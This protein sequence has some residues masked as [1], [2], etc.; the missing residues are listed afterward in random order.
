MKKSILASAILTALAATA[1]AEQTPDAEVYVGAS[2]IIWDDDR[3]LDDASA[4]ELGLEVPVSEAL[5]V[6]LWGNDYGTDNKQSEDLD[7]NRYSLGGLYHFNN[8]TFRPFVTLGGS[9][10]EMDY[11]KGT[12]DTDSLIYAGVGAKNYFENNIVV[13]GDLIAM[14]SLDHEVTD[15]AARIALGYAF[16]DT[17]ASAKANAKADAAAKQ[18]QMEADKARAAAAKA[19]AKAEAQ[20]AAEKAKAEAAKKATMDEKARAAAA[21]AASAAN[22]DADKDGVANSLDKC[23]ETN[24]AY[25][26]DA[27]GCPVKLN[28]TVSIKMNVQF[29]TNSTQV[30]P[31]SEAEIAAL[32]KFLKQFE[33]TNVTV[34]GHTDD[35]GRAA[36]NKSLSQKR[37]DAVKAKL[38]KEHGVDG[39]RI[40]AM[41][42]GEEQPIA[43]NATA[44]GRATNR[45]VVAVV[46]AQQEKLQTK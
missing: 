25:K 20:A 14:N 18:A 41:G 16:G 30:T 44:E 15:F 40:T 26:V 36:Y 13:R 21:A 12:E 9:H 31:N 6:E 43:S 4:L 29:E 10:Q 11:D 32:A 8:D 7:G 5:S 46:E 24:S 42:L 2:R 22:A 38:T 45:R 17:P 23:P 1:M 34:E 35:R 3:N 37:A 28:E 33:G 19:K 27:N 39:A